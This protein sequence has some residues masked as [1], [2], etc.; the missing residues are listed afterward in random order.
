MLR[1]AGHTPCFASQVIGARLATAAEARALG[2][3]RG[4]PLLTMTRTAWDTHGRA[5]EYGWH[6][7]RAGLYSLHVTIAGG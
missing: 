2:D 5:V 3:Q 4:A 6:V 7:Y 1:R